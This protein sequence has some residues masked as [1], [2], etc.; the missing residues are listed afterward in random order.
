MIIVPGS[1][2]LSHVGI[3]KWSQESLES[4]PTRL[5]AARRPDGPT[6][7]SLPCQSLCQSGG[8]QS[9]S[10]VEGGASASRTPDSR[11]CNAP[12]WPGGPAARP[13]PACCC[14]A[15]RGDKGL[16]LLLPSQLTTPLTAPQPFRPLPVLAAP[17]VTRHTRRM[18]PKPRIV[19][20]SL[21]VF[22]ARAPAEDVD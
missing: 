17:S 3:V 7:T 15:F 20:S 19:H 14:K 10:S 4:A 9:C 16:Q 6:F 22:R 8:F 2:P 13:G 21:M 11:H 5:R 1:G 18:A 12:Q